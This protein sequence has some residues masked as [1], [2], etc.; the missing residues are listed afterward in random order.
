MN[1]VWRVPC[2]VE[3]VRMYYDIKSLLREDIV[4]L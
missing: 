3:R 4:T 2:L 1:V